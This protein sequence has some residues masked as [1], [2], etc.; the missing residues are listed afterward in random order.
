MRKWM[1][2][3]KWWKP[4]FFFI[5]GGKCPGLKHPNS[6]SIFH[7]RTAAQPFVRLF[8]G[9]LGNEVTDD[10]RGA[11]ET[12]SMSRKWLKDGYLDS[13]KNFNSKII[14]PA[15]TTYKT[16]MV[17]T[18]VTGSKTQEANAL[19]LANAFRKYSSFQ[20]A[21]AWT[22]RAG[23]VIWMC[24]FLMVQQQQQQQQQQQMAFKFEKFQRPFPRLL[25]GSVSWGDSRQTYGKD[26]RHGWL[27][28][29]YLAL[30]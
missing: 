15:N 8:C 30:I 16:T 1:K 20:K 2:K 22:D 10:L 6:I 18:L 17:S 13:P 11:Q 24:F 21:K 3:S 28:V 7:D 27:W 14:K 26:Q 25:H 4:P 5:P 29:S 19:R 12:L 23:W 9:D